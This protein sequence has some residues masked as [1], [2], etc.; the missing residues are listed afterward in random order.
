MVHRR[1][2]LC[3]FSLQNSFRFIIDQ[4]IRLQRAVLQIVAPAYPCN[5]PAEY[6]IQYLDRSGFP[7]RQQSWFLPREHLSAYRY[8]TSCTQRSTVGIA[9]I[10]LAN[11]H[12]RRFQPSVKGSLPMYWP[13]G[14]KRSYSLPLSNVATCSCSHPPPLWR[15]STTTASFLR[16]LSLNKSE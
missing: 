5:L 16:L 13:R 6:R 15:V 1:F 4:D 10:I 14:T 9:V 11:Q 12:T 2:Q 8:P 7:T 3:I